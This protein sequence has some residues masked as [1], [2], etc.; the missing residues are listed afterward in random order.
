MKI[1]DRDQQ[2]RLDASVEGL[3]QARLTRREFFRRA[4]ALKVFLSDMNDMPREGYLGVVDW[5]DAAVHAGAGWDDAQPAFI[6]PPGQR[7]KLHVQW[8]LPALSSV[9]SSLPTPGSSHCT[10][11]L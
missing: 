3:F 8:E 4:T 7:Y 2:K 10:W 5:P 1:N 11:S 9:Y 6:A